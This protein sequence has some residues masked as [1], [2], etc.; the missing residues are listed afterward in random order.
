MVQVLA[1]VGEEN[2]EVFLILL[3]VKLEQHKTIL[4]DGLWGLHLTS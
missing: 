3:L 1:Y 4:T 2:G